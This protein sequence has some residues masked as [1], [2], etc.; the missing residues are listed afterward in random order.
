[1]TRSVIMRTCLAGGVCLFLVIAALCVATECRPAAET[2]DPAIPPPLPASS[3]PVADRVPLD[4][5]TQEASASSVLSAP[6]PRREAPVPHTPGKTP[7]PH[8]HRS[9]I[10]TELPPEPTAPVTGT[11]RPA[12]PISGSGGR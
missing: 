4:D 1:M 2:D 8:E 7:G 11:P 5:P 10:T 6:L 9:A 12:A 3:G